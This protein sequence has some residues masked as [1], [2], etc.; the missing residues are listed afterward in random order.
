MGHLL[1]ANEKSFQILIGSLSRFSR[2]QV[3]RE[4]SEYFIIQTR[5]SFY[6]IEID[7]SHDL[8]KGH[9]FV[10]W[11]ETKCHGSAGR[12]S[13]PKVQ[14]FKIRLTLD[15]LSLRSHSVSKSVP[16]AYQGTQ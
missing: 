9:K 1:K 15:S 7:I 4:L 6:C 13:V 5:G 3:K 8:W 12:A 10:F 16:Q 2:F 11:S 14:W